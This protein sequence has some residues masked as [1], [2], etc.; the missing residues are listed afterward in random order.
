MN[1]PFQPL[2]RLLRRAEVEKEVGLSRSTIYDRMEKG[3]FPRGRIVGKRARR[4]PSEEI[5]R[6]K[7]EQPTG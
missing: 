6:W 4:W 2:G 3:T 7:Q 5:E 1:A